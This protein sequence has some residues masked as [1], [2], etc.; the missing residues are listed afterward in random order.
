VFRFST[1]G[2]NDK[3]EK[4]MQE[5]V[6][7]KIDNLGTVSFSFITFLALTLTFLA[8]LSSSP[9]NAFVVLVMATN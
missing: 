7:L 3:Q 1:F 2:S 5:I 4:Q 8:S 6:R 9:S